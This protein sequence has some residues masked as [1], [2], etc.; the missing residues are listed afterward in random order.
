MYKRL[1]SSV[2]LLFPGDRLHFPEE[3]LMIGHLIVCLSAELNTL[4][5]LAKQLREV[6]PYVMTV[7]MPDSVKKWLPEWMPMS[8]PIPKTLRK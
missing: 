7:R 4:N 5:G 3:E 8:Q 1:I 6:D 2:L